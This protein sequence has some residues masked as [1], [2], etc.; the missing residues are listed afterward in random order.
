MLSIVILSLCWC[1]TE[2]VQGNEGICNHLEQNPILSHSLCG[3]DPKQLCQELMGVGKLKNSNLCPHSLFP[4]APLVTGWGLA[5]S[6]SQI[7]LPA[8]AKAL[9]LDS[10][11][12]S[13]QGP[14]CPGYKVPDAL[15]P[16]SHLNWSS[17]GWEESSNI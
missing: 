8:T 9:A 14:V 11:R 2:E 17:A 3:T 4:L 13:G 12:V 16:S 7:P 10:A 15:S 5:C 6:H 1:H